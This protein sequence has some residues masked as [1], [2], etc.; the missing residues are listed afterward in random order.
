M[1]KLPPA[2]TSMP[3]SFQTAANFTRL[4]ISLDHNTL[5]FWPLCHI[6][7]RG[8]CLDF[9]SPA[10]PLPHILVSA[11]QRI[12][13]QSS[14]LGILYHSPPQEHDTFKVLILSNSEAVQIYAKQQVNSLP[15]PASVSAPNWGILGICERSIEDPT[16]S[17]TLLLASILLLHC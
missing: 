1:T 17:F 14:N 11:L 2:L 4:F 6:P 5:F 8:R 15:L 10:P 3:A 13:P 16:P 7:Q 9:H 12:P